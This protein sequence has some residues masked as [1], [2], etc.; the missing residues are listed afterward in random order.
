[1]FEPLTREEIAQRHDYWRV[2]N[3]L[4]VGQIHLEDNT[5]LDRPLTKDDIKLWLLG[6]GGTTAGLNFIYT[7]LHRIIKKHDLNMMYI[8]SPGHGGPGLIVHTYLEG[9]CNEIYPGV[10]QNRLPCE[11]KNEEL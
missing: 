11:Q 4:T 10:E 5:L 9:S 7:H 2:S 6:H 1:M 8:I 3:Y